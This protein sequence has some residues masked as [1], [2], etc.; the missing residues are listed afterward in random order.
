M[1]FVYSSK[2]KNLAVVSETTCQGIKPFQLAIKSLY[3]V[4]SE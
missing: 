1:Y 4:R 2:E 3:D